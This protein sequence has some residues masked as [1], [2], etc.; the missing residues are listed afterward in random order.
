MFK[1]QDL[2]DAGKRFESTQRAA[3]AKSGV[4]ITSGSA[5]EV[6]AES[7]RQIEKEITRV[8]YTGGF[9][10]QSA[11]TMEDAFTRASNYALIGGFLK[12]GALAYGGWGKLED[13]KVKQ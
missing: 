10:V 1:V 2:E 3:Y 11:Q 7:A 4:D 12:G 6:T 13:I 8:K 5:A 9:Q